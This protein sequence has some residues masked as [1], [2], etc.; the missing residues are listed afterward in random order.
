M[1][2]RYLPVFASFSLLCAPFISTA[3]DQDHEHS[4]DTDEDVF[5]YHPGQVD[6]ITGEGVNAGGFIFPELFVIGTGGLF[7]PGVEA[8]DLATTEHDPQNDIGIQIIELHLEI[9]I[10]DR[11]TGGIYGAGFQGEDEW[12][13]NLEEYYLHYWLTDEIGI[14]GGQFLNAFGFQATKHAHG[15]DFVNQ[16]LINSRMLNEG[17]LITQGGELLFNVPSLDGLLSL[18]G[19][20]VRTHAHDEHGHGHGEEEEEHDHDELAHHEEE[21][22]H[23][24]DE[25]DHHEEEEHH[26]E[27]GHGL[28]AD[29]ANFNDWVF[30]TDYKFGLPFDDGLTGSVSFATGENG[31]GRQTYVY[32]FGFE[33]VWNGHDHGSGPEFCT[34]ALMLRSEFIGRE[35]KAVD[36]T[37]REMN[38]DDYGVSTALFYGL[39]DNTTVS[40]RHDWVS[41]LAGLG[42]EDRHRISP[43]ITT[44]LD[45]NQRIRAR[46]QY[47]YN[48]S[49]SLPNEHAAWLQIQIAWGGEGGAH[50][51]H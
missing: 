15:W 50:H 12:E 33:K 16:N 21:D 46:L 6:W 20:G 22:H 8:T 48:H 26:D 49:D 37:G 51:H 32:G 11:I 44:F 38:F 28:E 17:E 1:K 34:E 19:G 5:E 2:N 35:I 45:K 4:V 9:E 36:D 27:E 23:D 30:S 43:A 10:N 40:L 41:D 13:A 25:E 18:G 29:D 24:E 31:F 7:Q 47:D 3:E 42:L 39:S 14:G